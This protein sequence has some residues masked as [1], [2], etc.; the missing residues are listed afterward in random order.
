MKSEV[1]LIGGGGHCRS[2]IDVIEQEGCFTIAGVVERKSVDIQEPVMGYSILGNDDDLPVLR[3]KYQYALITVGQIDSP[4]PRIRLFEKLLRLGFQLPIITS[5]LAYVSRYANIDCGTV[6]MHHALVNAGATIG[7]NCII[8]S[9]ALIEHDVYIEDHCHIAPGAVLSGGTSI[10]RAVF[11]GCN[12]MSRE[13][14]SIGAESLIGGGV[15]VMK[16][17]PENSKIKAP[18]ARG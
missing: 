13:Q 7:R 6:V 12:A 10:G 5:P 14:I 18:F 1:L 15:S 9:K 11:F 16:N 4:F 2:C 17:L 3:Q 8:N